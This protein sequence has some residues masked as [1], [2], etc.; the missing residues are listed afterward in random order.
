MITGASG[1]GKELVARSIHE[2]SDRAHGPFVAFNCGALTETLIDN[3]L[4]GHEKGAYTGAEEGSPG[5]IEVANGGTLF[6]DEIGEI[7]HAMQV[8][9][10]RVLQEKELLRVGGRHPIALNV[11]VI[12]AT[13]KDPKTAVADGSLRTDFLFRINVFHIE[14]PLL[15]EHR[16]DIP[17]LAYH[18]LNRLKT[19]GSKPISAITQ[20]AMTL[21]THYAYPG[22][23]RELENILERAVAVC[24]GQM[25]RVSDLPADLSEFELLAYHR[26]EGQLMTLEALEQD[27]ISHVL[28][29]T[30]GVRNRAA[31]ILG[32][33][34]ASLWR[35]IKKFGLE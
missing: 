17:L 12:T 27:Y 7:P 33:D 26:P 3:E 4:F 32:I 9:L 19:R 18:I 35:K 1:T 13:A 28:R 6:L 2:L 15:S 10:L 29:L 11:R 5:L 14:L 24:S 20:N 30:D 16:E 34:R 25:I 31:E 22:N 23:V 8:K 21:L